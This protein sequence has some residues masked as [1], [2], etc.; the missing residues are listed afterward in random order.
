MWTMYKHARLTLDEYGLS[1]GMANHGG[2]WFLNF[3]YHMIQ[4]VCFFKIKV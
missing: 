1:F 3:T 4:K 2:N